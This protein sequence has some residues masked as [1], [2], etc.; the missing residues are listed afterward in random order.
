MRTSNY[1]HHR[2]RSHNK[3]ITFAPRGNPDLPGNFFERVC[4][5]ETFDINSI[6]GE[7]DA[8]KFLNSALERNDDQDMISRLSIPVGRK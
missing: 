4:N 8:V 7:A 2:H 5:K 1:Q 6:K 3:S